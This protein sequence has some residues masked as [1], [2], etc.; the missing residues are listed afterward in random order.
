MR[1]QT[2]QDLQHLLLD[3][4][5][6]FVVVM[7]EEGINVVGIVTLHDLLRAQTAAAERAADS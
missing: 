4:T 7:D 3:S 5:T 6:H 2:I 1:G